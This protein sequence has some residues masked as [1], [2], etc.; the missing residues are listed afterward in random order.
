[1]STG[2]ILTAPADATSVRLP[3]LLCAGD[4]ATRANSAEGV[5]RVHAP[6]GQTGGLRID[7]QHRQHNNPPVRGAHPLSGPSGLA[8]APGAALLPPVPSPQP[9]P[10]ASRPCACITA[11]PPTTDSTRRSRIRLCARFSRRGTACAFHFHLLSWRALPA[12]HP[13]RPENAGQE[14]SGY[15]TMR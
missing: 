3:R 15:T 2:E 12:M 10:R 6:A 9:R 4:R 13:N 14:G 8:D 1:M 11:H 5:P 7:G